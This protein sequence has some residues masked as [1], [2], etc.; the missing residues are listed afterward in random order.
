MVYVIHNEDNWIIGFS[1]SEPTGHDKYFQIDMGEAVSFTRNP[2]LG[3]TRPHLLEYDSFHRVIGLRRQMSSDND[4]FVKVPLGLI[5]LIVK[6]TT[7][8]GEAQ[9][10][11]ETL[12]KARELEEEEKFEQAFSLERPI[13]KKYS[14]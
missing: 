6:A 12:Q 4:K 10:D 11:A 3:Q 9:K 7:N 2:R 8:L 14:D 1:E 5:H 13:Y